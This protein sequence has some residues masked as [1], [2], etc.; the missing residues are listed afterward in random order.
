MLWNGNKCGKTK[1][2]K[3]SRQKFPVKFMIDHKQFE[4]VEYLNIWVGC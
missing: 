4:N 3:N 1:V 2:M